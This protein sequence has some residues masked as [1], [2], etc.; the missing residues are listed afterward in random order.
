[1]ATSSKSP[2]QKFP[3]FL[4]VVDI[5]RLAG[6]S[7]TVV[8]RAERELRLRPYI[9]NERGDRRFSDDQGKKIIRWIERYRNPSLRMK[10]IRG[11]GR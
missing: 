10:E 9:L 4:R 1:V 8:L 7:R 5:E 11:S 6:C 2:T 3:L